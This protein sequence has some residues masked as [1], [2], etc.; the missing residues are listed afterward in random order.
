M[1]FQAFTVSLGRSPVSKSRESL[2]A[3]QVNAANRGAI[4]ADECLQSGARVNHAN[5]CVMPA[6]PALLY[7]PLSDGQ[8]K[9]RGKVTFD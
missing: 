2:A 6:G 9:I 7:C 8:S 3:A 5:L 4:V 1:D